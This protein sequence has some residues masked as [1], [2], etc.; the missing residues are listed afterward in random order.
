M[1][2]VITGCTRGIGL[3]IVEHLS[4]QEAHRIIGI[5]RDK[6]TL[7]SLSN[8]LHSSAFF[9]IV[10]DLTDLNNYQ[11]NLLGSIVQHTDT[12]DI[13]IN[14]AGTLVKAPFEEFTH[15]Q[16]MQQF[17]IN[18]FSPAHLIKLLLPLMGKTNRSHVV[19]IGSM[20]GV[21]G[22]Q[23][24]AG[25]SYYSAGKAAIAVLTECLAEEYKNRNIAFNCLALGA[26]QTDMLEKAFP[27]LK[28]PVSPCQ[29][30]SFI[31]DFALTGQSHFNGKIIPV[32]LSVP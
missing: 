31:A 7:T 8:K 24:F 5:A 13:L 12:V 14:N 9:P 28:A 18:F 16:A 4:K 1:N 29:M 21:M 2:I 30:G 3:S 20:G 15:E 11:S 19:N 22:S 17:E 6:Q 10:Y 25:L 27:G 26:V 32:S 23:K